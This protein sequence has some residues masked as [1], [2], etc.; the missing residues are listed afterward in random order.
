MRLWHPWIGACEAQV[1]SSSAADYP[2]F[3][4]RRHLDIS[5]Y[6]VSSRRVGPTSEARCGCG[7]RAL[8]TGYA[9]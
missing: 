5:C 7:V 3:D 9:S 8:T 6:M 1:Y 2:G 4:I